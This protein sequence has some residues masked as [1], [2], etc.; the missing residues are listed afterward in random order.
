MFPETAKT[1]DFKC[2]TGLE[3][4]RIFSTLDPHDHEVRYRYNVT[5][6]PGDPNFEIRWIGYDDTQDGLKVTVAFTL[7]S[8]FWS[9][10]ITAV[11][12]N[13]IDHVP[14]FSGG[15][16]QLGGKFSLFEFRIGDLKLAAVKELRAELQPVDFVEFHNIALYPASSTVAPKPK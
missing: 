9:R 13:G 1:A 14:N 5:P 8:R 3:P 7:A 2:P 4:V 16:P 6:R 11:D 12:T 15:G 10:R